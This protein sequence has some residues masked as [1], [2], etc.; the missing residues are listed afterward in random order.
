[1]LFLNFLYEN[2]FSLCDPCSSEISVR[3]ELMFKKTD[4]MF[5][6]VCV[7]VDYRIFYF[8]APDNTSLAER[9][10]FPEAAYEKLSSF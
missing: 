1:M 6:D 2:T 9:Q 5:T 10:S 7:S 3:F 4:P 8:S